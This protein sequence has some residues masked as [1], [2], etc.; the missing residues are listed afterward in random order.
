MVARF[1][2]D[3]RLNKMAKKDYSLVPAAD[4]GE[5]LYVLDAPMLNE[6]GKPLVY[7]FGF[8]PTLHKYRMDTPGKLKMGNN[9]FVGAMS[10]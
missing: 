10:D 5:D 4:G 7:P 1:A 6:T 2:G 9:I 3:I 8:A